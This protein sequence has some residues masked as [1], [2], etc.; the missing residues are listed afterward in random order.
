MGINKY[1]LHLKLTQHCQSSTCVSGC[2]QS[3]PALCGPM[4]CSPPGSSVH[5]ILQP[6]ILEWVAVSSSRGSSGTMDRTHVSCIGRQILF[7]RAT[8]EEPNQV[9]S[10]IKKNF[11]SAKKRTYGIARPVI[12]GRSQTSGESWSFQAALVQ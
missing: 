5:G 10:N 3:C 7:H 2:A 9:Y 11:L 6:R 12:L 1:T 4:D 8:L